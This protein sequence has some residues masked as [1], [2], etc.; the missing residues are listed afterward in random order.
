MSPRDL[1]HLQQLRYILVRYTSLRARCKRIPR[2]AANI[3]PL[4]ALNLSEFASA[5]NVPSPDAPL[6][7]A[8]NTFDNLYYWFSVGE[9]TLPLHYLSDQNTPYNQSPHPI[10]SADKYPLQSITSSYF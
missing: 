2:A 7:S 10:F 3:F 8:T 4:E 1:E 9:A 5:K 6:Y